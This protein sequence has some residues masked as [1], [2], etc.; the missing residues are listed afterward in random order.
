MNGE[1]GEK[2]KNS[3]R[4]VLRKSLLFSKESSLLGRRLNC[5]STVVDFV[6]LLKKEEHTKALEGHKHLG[7]GTLEAMKVIAET[8]YRDPKNITSA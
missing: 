4:E 1:L 3:V 6:I 7:K 8:I 5:Y 2:D